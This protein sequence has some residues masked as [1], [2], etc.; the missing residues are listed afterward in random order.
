MGNY[1]AVIFDMDG[2]LLNT[3]DDIGDSVNF[4]M[5]KYGFPQRTMDEIRSFVGNGVV[6]LLELS[7]PGGKEN[8]EFENCL[9]E[10]KDHYRSNMLNKTAPYSGILELLRELDKKNCSLAIVSNKFDRAVKDLNELFFKEYVRVAVGES[11]AVRKKPAPDSVIEALRELGASPEKALYVGDSEVD[12]ETA[13]NSGLT[14]VGVTWGF[15][16][17]NVLTDA[18]ADYI[19]DRPGELLNIIG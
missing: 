13:K 2:T 11:D 9:R 4:I 18:G 14:S 12:V 3:L 6:R 5:D 17:R 8:P 1:N 10:Y 19:I 7:V 15:R 16:D